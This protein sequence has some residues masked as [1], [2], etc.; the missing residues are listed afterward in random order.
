MATGV[1]AQ[2][3]KV[4]PGR[5][6]VRDQVSH[7]ERHPQGRRFGI[8]HA[9]QV[10]TVNSSHSH[11]T[12]T[13]LDERG[14]DSANW[15]AAATFAILVLAMSTILHDEGHV[16]RALQA[17]ACLA[18]P[19]LVAMAVRAGMVATRVAG[20][21]RAVLTVLCGSVLVFACTM[22]LGSTSPQLTTPA[23]MIA[24][25]LLPAGGVMTLLF[26]PA[27][28]SGKAQQRLAALGIA[29]AL[30][31]SCAT[32][33]LQYSRHTE[34][35]SSRKSPKQQRQRRAVPGANVNV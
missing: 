34:P 10:V 7:Y 32:A 21:L 5:L 8:E 22:A 13:G 28:S 12:R 35:G 27:D 14:L 18:V 24:T 20:S 2:G 11:M 29:F 31:W 23:T 9:E 26:A 25:A 17:W 6:Y 1:H 16:F 3:G 4:G 33:T 19:V 15:S 30:L